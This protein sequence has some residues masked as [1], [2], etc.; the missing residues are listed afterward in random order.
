MTSALVCYPLDLVRAVMTVQTS[1]VP[2]YSSMTAAL[3]GIYGT[4]GVRGLYRG[5]SP[6]LVG[7]APYIALNFTTFDILKRSFV[8]PRGEPY[9]DVLNLTCGAFAGGFAATCGVSLIVICSDVS[10]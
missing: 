4:E 9:F 3:R 1:A 5:L 2:K 7:I 10:H 6:T 8:P